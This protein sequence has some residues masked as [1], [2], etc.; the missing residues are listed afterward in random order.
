MRK[1]FDKASFT[2]SGVTA[3]RYAA[4]NADGAGRTWRDTARH[5]IKGREEGGSFDVRYFEV[6]QDGFTSLEC[7]EHI[8][9]VICVRGRGY[10][11]VGDAVMELEPFDHLYVASQTPH[12]FV[13]Q[14]GEPFGFL[15][16]VDAQRDRPRALTPAELAALRANPATARKIKT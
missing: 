1:K 6:A 14:G 13:N 3:Q 5:I 7:H 12:Q 9:S 2:W 4:E 10:A 16:I 8:H 11:V 15:C